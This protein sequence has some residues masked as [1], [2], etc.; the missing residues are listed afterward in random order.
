MYTDLSNYV[1]GEVL[2]RG[3]DSEQLYH[4]WNCKKCGREYKTTKLTG[5]SGLCYECLDKNQKEKQAKAKAK[6]LKTALGTIRQKFRKKFN[7]KNIPTVV[8]DGE[9][10]YQEKA[11]K[12]ALDEIFNEIQEQIYE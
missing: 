12:K 8:V 4:F 3:T 6:A 1:R 5:L 7:I 11:F 2:Y 9:K 10:Y